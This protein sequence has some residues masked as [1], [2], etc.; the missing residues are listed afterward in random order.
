MSLGQI[1][2][3]KREQ[4]NPTLDEVSENGTVWD[5]N[6]SKKFFQKIYFYF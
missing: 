5:K 4:L 1:I 3:K 2:R 6:E